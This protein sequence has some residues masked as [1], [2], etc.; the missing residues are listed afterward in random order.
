[1]KESY[2]KGVAN[3][4]ASSLAGRVVRR[5]S[6]RRREE[7]VGWVSSFENPIRDADLV[8]RWGRPHAR[9]RKREPVGGPA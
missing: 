6:K 8:D 3:H 9:R 2:R 1:M 5:D 7:S 4:L